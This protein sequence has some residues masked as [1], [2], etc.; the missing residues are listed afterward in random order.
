MYTEIDP[1]GGGADG[2]GTVSIDFDLSAV[3]GAKVAAD[4]SV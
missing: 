4:P 3:P 2:V 1:T